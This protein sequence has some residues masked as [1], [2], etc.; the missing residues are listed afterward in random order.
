MHSARCYL[1]LLNL[2]QYVLAT[3]FL[4]AVFFF[5]PLF[6]FIFKRAPFGSC[7]GY[8]ADFSFSMQ[9]WKTNGKWKGSFAGG[10]CGTQFPACNKKHRPVNGKIF[11]MP[12][13]ACFEME[14][15]KAEIERERIWPLLWVRMC[16]KDGL[17]GLRSMS[18]EYINLKVI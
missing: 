8:G 11:Q 7:L 13:F 2:L 1:F 16:I 12:L 10:L 15:T 14:N 6:V 18:L 4:F 3:G 9:I 5:W 17:Q